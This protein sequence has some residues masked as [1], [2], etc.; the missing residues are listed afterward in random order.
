M[1]FADTPAPPYWA[2]LFTSRRNSGDAEGY[3]RMAD[4][5]SAL[6]PSQPG[7][8]GIE[9]VRG[10]DGVGITVSYWRD[11]ASIAAWKRLSAHVAAQQAGHE[12]WYEDF[13]VRVARVER[14]YTMAGSP[15]EGLE[16]GEA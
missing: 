12:R 4:A 9:S 5:M 14:A 13:V 10:A 16:P 8:L 6:A 1:A 11:E 3:A 7:Y 15:R 2:V